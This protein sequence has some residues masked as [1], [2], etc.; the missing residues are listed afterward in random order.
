MSLYASGVTLDLAGERV[1]EREDQEED[2][3]EQAC[4]LSRL[5]E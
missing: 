5:S 2:E 1:V 4:H 3:C